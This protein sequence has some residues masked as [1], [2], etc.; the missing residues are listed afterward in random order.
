LLIQLSRPRNNPIEEDISGYT[1]LVSG[2][3][4]ITVRPIFKNSTHHP[5][6]RH[7][8]REILARTPRPLC[9][10]GCCPIIAGC[11]ATLITVQVSGSQNV[12]PPPTIGEIA[13][14]CKNRIVVT[15]T[16]RINRTVPYFCAR[17]LTC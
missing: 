14:I 17:Q 7:L 10:V 13:R 11:E 6:L 1:D 2:G 12:G 9:L 16:L 4:G 8:G 3:K 5:V 15:Q